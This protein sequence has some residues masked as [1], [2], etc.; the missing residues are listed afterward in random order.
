MVLE[1]VKPDTWSIWV[2]VNGFSC[3]RYA[4]TPV[5][6]VSN[7]VNEIVTL[8]P[9]VSKSASYPVEKD[10]CWASLD[11][12]EHDETSSTEIFITWDDPWSETSSVATAEIWWSPIATLDHN[13][14]KG[15]EVSSPIF[16]EPS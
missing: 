2:S 5:L 16:S 11:I 6:S 12:S 3:H 8:E 15:S 14:V 4:T 1:N 9:T 13:K 7:S 10:P